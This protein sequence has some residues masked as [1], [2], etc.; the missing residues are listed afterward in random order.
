MLFEEIWIEQ[1]CLMN[2]YIVA[3]INNNIWKN[4]R[5]NNL[6]K[7]HFNFYVKLLKNLIKSKENLL[8]LLKILFENLFFVIN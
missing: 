2:L 5:I 6:C 8:I 7:Q 4:M 3:W 1:F